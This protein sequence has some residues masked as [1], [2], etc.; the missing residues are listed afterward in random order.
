GA[1]VTNNS[2]FTVTPCGQ[3]SGGSSRAFD[4][5]LDWDKS[6]RGNILSSFFYGYICTQ[7]LGGWLAGRY[8]GKHV[9]GTAMVIAF[10]MTMVT[11]I[12]SRTHPYLVIAAR[13]LMGL[14][15]GVV[16][17][18]MHAVWGKWAP[19][20]ERSKL[21]SFCYS[22]TIIGNI[23]A[24]SLSGFLC[25]IQLDNGWPFIFYVYGAFCFL[26]LCG[27]YLTVF[28]TPASHPRIGQPERTYIQQSIGHHP[29]LE[30]VSVPWLTFAKSPAVWAIIVAHTCNNWGNYTLMTSLPTFMKEVLAFDVKQN[31]LFSALPYLA[32]YVST[33]L[34]GQIADRLRERRVLNTTWTRKLFQSIGGFLPAAFLIATGFVDCETRMIGVAFLTLGVAFTA[35]V[36]AGF[37]INHVD[38]APRF[39]GEIYG[40]TNTLS[41]IP[42]MVSPIAVGALTPNGSKEE[43]QRVL[44]IS[45]AIYTFGSLFFLVFASGEE[46]TWDKPDHLHYQDDQ[47]LKEKE[48]KD[49]LENTTL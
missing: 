25:E 23:V 37:Q 39:A 26:W 30:K 46:Q 9:L 28:D 47:E 33:I 19:P 5:E 20:L 7:I 6:L 36:R 15:T 14:A 48:K 16:F 40:I 1:N 11:P 18:A 35:G 3:L 21:M 34:F 42:G 24:L 22:G 32:M 41:T 12:A 45:G 17:P 2:D 43:W 27:W 10:A 4:G 29:G 31:G 8:G 38:I 13:V 49:D 44:F